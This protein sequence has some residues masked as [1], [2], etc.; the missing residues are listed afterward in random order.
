MFFCSN[1]NHKMASPSESRL[2]LTVLRGYE[3]NSA[4]MEPNELDEFQGFRVEALRDWLVKQGWRNDTEAGPYIWRHATLDR[5]VGVPTDPGISG[6]LK[7]C[8]LFVVAD[9]ADLSVQELLR[10]VNPRLRSGWPSEDDLKTH[11][12]WLVNCP[13]LDN[14]MRVWESDTMRERKE[15]VPNAVVECWPVDAAGNKVRWK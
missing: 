8:W 13:L 7:W 4:I 6:V 1:A 15:R 9:E 12:R 14:T 5:T 10:Q 3:L 11:E 2:D